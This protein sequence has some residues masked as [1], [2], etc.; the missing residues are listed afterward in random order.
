MGRAAVLLASLL[1]AA[2]AVADDS[3]PNVLFAVSDDQS[4]V[5]ASAYGYQAIATPGFVWE[6]WPR[7]R[8]PTPRWA[9]EDPE[10]VPRQEWLEERRPQ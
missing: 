1:A 8:F 6:T 3:R 7:H 9:L 5:H 10:S 2:P 4:W